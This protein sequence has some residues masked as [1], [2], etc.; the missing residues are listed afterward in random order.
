MRGKRVA[1]AAV[2][3]ALCLYGL[4]VTQT[5]SAIAGVAVGT[6]V[7]WGFQISR[8]RAALAVAAV[9]GALVLVLALVGPFRERSLV[10]LAEVA[11]GDW[12]SVLTGRLDGWRAAVW[13][14]G[15][16]P[17]T[18]VGVGAYRTEFVPAKTALLRDGVVF[19]VDQLNVVFANAHNELLEVAAETGWPGLAAFVFGLGMLVR[20]LLRRRAESSALDRRPRLGRQRRDH[21]PVA[22]QFSVPD[23]RRSLAD[24]SLRRLDARRRGERMKLVLRLLLPAL[25]AVGL[26][27]QAQRAANLTRAQRLCNMVERRTLAMLRSGDLD[28]AKLRAHVAALGDAQK[29]DR[30]DVAIPTL[31][32]SQHLMLGELA[33]ARKV[34]LAAQRLEPRPE[35]LVNLGKVSYSQAQGERAVRYFARAVALD[36]W[37]EREVPESLRA[38]VAAAAKSLDALRSQDDADGADED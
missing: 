36:P 1:L 29:L 18:G 6:I 35:I 8:R 19:F 10:K 11:R 2:A 30:A 26:V 9:A 7:F 3:L 22:G 33:L 20:R 25:L 12:N 13:M 28:K 34:Y 31:L 17:L 23:R 5:F 24:L 21:R 38:A 27:A 14:V 37:L 16:H 32:G 4:I 15:E